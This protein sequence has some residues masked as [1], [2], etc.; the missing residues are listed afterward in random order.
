MT[1][2]P[3]AS[4]PAPQDS[5]A[6]AYYDQATAPRVNT[7][8]V[9]VNALRA[10]YP[11]L[12]LTV[13]PQGGCDLLA[14]AAAGFAGVAPIDKEQDRLAWKIFAAPARRLNGEHGVLLDNV[15]FGKFLIDWNKRE[16]VVY[17]ANGRDGTLPYGITINQYILSSSIEATN[18]LLLACGSWSTDLHNEIWVFDG[19]RWQKSAELWQ[20]VQKARWED[21]ILD[22]DMK[23]SVIKDVENFFDNRETYARL[24]VPWKRGIIY[25]GPPGN[26]KTISIKAMMHSLY[27]RKEPVPTLYVRTLASFAGPEYSLRQ[28]FLQ[29]RRYAPCYLVFEDLDS[30]V[31]DAVRSYFLNEVDGLQSNGMLAFCSFDSNIL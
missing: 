9:V 16:F 11:Q 12:H 2:G 18:N 31:S 21:V 15:H 24:R 19:G 6:T 14:Y 4:R 10:E 23:K 27:A 8:I 3:G 29:A 17:I 13:A 20:S 1:A 25:Y 22:E 7:D 28:I 5:A 30:L 26:G